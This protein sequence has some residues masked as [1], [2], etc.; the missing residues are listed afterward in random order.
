ME[1]SVAKR[2]RL[3]PQNAEEIIREQRRI[4]ESQKT[5]IERQKMRIIE[6]QKT[7]IENQKIVIENQEAQIEQLVQEQCKNLELS[8]TET[9]T[10]TVSVP[11]LPNEIWLEI[12]SYLST[13]DVLKNMAQVSKRFHKLSQDPDV[14]RKI[15]ADS[16]QSW[17]EDENVRIS[18][19]L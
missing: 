11:E 2:P 15:E 19:A 14:I 8:A 12:V 6:S 16:V 5:V 17:P 4:I 10:K 9:K 7:V 3:E 18:F 13:C 1:T